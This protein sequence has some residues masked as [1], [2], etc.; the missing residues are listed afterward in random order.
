MQQS[1]QAL[2]R[3][4][5]P[6]YYTPGNHDIGDNPDAKTLAQYTRTSG[7]NPGCEPP[8]DLVMVSCEP[9]NPKPSTQNTTMT[10]SRGKS[11]L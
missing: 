7:D 8:K 5:I 3:A 4:G 2:D 9:L 10:F 1:V 11:C 6:V